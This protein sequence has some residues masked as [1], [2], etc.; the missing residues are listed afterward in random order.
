MDGESRVG[1]GFSFSFSSPPSACV[2]VAPS[3]V[4][5]SRLTR[6]APPLPPRRPLA[7]PT[8]TECKCGNCIVTSPHIIKSRPAALDW[9]F[10]GFGALPHRARAPSLPPGPIDPRILGVMRWTVDH[11]NNAFSDRHW[12]AQIDGQTPGIPEDHQ[13]LTDRGW[14]YGFEVADFLL[15][16]TALAVATVDP[17]TDR[18]VYVA[19]TKANFIV[20]PSAAVRLFILHSWQKAWA[21]VALAPRHP[22]LTGAGGVA[23]PADARAAV[24]AAMRTLGVRSAALQ[25][26]GDSDKAQRHRAAILAD[27]GLDDDDDVWTAFWRV[28]GFW[29]GDGSMGYTRGGL[30]RVVRFDQGKIADK[31]ALPLW[32]EAMGV[33]FDVRHDDFIQSGGTLPTSHYEISSKKLVAFFHRHFGMKYVRSTTYRSR[34]PPI[35][36]VAADTLRSTIASDPGVLTASSDDGGGDSSSDTGDGGDDFDDDDDNS[37]VSGGSS[38]GD[39]TSGGSS[40]DRMSSSDKVSDGGSGTTFTTVATAGSD[41]WTASGKPLDDFMLDVILSLPAKYAQ[42]LLEGLQLADGNTGVRV[43]YASDPAFVATIG[44]VAANAGSSPLPSCL[45][46]AGRVT[47]RSDGHRI[48]STVDSWSLSYPRSLVV[49]PTVTVQPAPAESNTHLW[50]L[51]LPHAPAFVLVRRTGVNDAGRSV[52]FRPIVVGAAADAVAAASGTPPPRSGAGSD[53]SSGAGSD[54][55]ST[56]GEPEASRS[57]KRRRSRRPAPVGDG[58]A[59]DA[60]LGDVAATATAAMAAPAPAPAP[61]DAVP[62]GAQAASNRRRGRA[63]AAAS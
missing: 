26:V 42:A 25:G 34:P 59:A 51:H 1:R 13:I 19:I 2:P 38:S 17:R 21:S 39:D 5:R 28:M 18:I 27:L 7:R 47:T 36:P 16:G 58:T 49:H 24:P 15:A 41:G 62:G 12:P 20:S 23:L 46:P 56:G 14:L 8:D 37:R 33:E 32:L 53:E 30:P 52:F 57:P 50:G 43:I 61:A 29:L 3:G 60:T 40:S 35:G 31:V 55:E 4:P 54:A 22:V 6:P 45:H 44:A 10:Q 48:T 63:P 9:T 11:V